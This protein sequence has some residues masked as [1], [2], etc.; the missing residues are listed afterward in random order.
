[1]K[2]WIF[3]NN[4]VSGPYDADDLSQLPGYSAES[5]VCPEGRKGTSMGDWQRAGLVPALSLSLAKATQ[6]AAAGKGAAP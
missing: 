4:Q 3:Q 1:M 2:Y 5:L 6:F